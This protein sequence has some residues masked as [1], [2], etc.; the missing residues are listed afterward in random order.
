MARFEGSGDFRH[1]AAGTIGV[2]VVNLG[3]P[4]APTTAAVRRYLAEFLWDPRVVELPRPLWW[5]ILHGVILP[6][7]PSRSA[8]AYQQIWTDRGS[9][10][11]LHSAGIVAGLAE[12]LGPGVAVELGMT[13]GQPSIAAALGRLK[14][15]GLR[16]LVVLPLYPQYS[17]STSGSVF[18]RVATELQGWRWVPDLHFVSSYHDD[19]LHIAALAASVREHF[20]TQ[21]RSHLLMSFHGTPRAFL[22]AG[23]PYHCQCRKTARL[24]AEALDLGPHD[25]T[26]TFQSRLGRAEWLQPYTDSELRALPGRGIKRLAMICPG[27]AVDCL[28]TLEEIALRGRET[29]IAAG[30]ESC[31]FIPCLNTGAAHLD[32]LAALLR[33]RSSGWPEAGT[34]FDAAADALR[35]EQ[36]AA[37]AQA[38]GG[39]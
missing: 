36:T 4:D 10:L 14:E 8:H 23:D 30:G 21:G 12:R 18:D 5:L 31:E 11:K 27:F 26:L 2:L 20:A 33:A 6:F 19:P 37:R 22:D 29:F 15:R 32:A 39:S 16:R 25:W 7:R 13:Y 17:G 35:R 34:P 1:D 9:P 3:T 38:L 28:E 24:L